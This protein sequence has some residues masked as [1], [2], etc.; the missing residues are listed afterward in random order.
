M[1]R[2]ARKLPGMPDPSKKVKGPRGRGGLRAQ[3]MG[4]LESLERQADELRAS[5]A[6]IVAA[7]DAERRQVE[8]DL[9]DGAQQD[10]VVVDLKL[11][12]LERKLGENE[13]A[14]VMLE[15]IR[16]DL[17]RAIVDLRHL[18]HGIYPPLLANEGLSGALREAV[19]RAGIPA[20]FEST[21]IGR[22]APELEAAVYFCCREALQNA[23]KHAGVGAQ[24]VVSLHETPAELR[25][26]VADDGRGFEPAA[27]RASAGLPNMADRVG[28][29]GGT[30]EVEASPGIGTRVRGSI[31]LS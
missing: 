2:A 13:E 31:P 14:L 26:E 30:L 11:G 1:G 29:L 5:R 6:R 9:H 17:A 3:N 15:E 23:A 16:A 25:F 20:S 18:A 19:A 24:A 7:A 22:H 27:A 10:L 28:A 4:L 21:D 8:R 12:I